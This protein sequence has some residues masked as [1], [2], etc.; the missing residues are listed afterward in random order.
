MRLTSNPKNE[1]W[2]VWSPDGTRIVFSSDRAGGYAL[3]QR[4]SSGTGTEEQL[5]AVEGSNLGAEHLSSDGRWL[6]F[7][8]F[9]PAKG[10]DIYLLPMEGT[11]QPVPYLKEAAGE[12]SPRFS[13]DGRWIAYTSNETG[14]AEVYVQPYPASGAKWTISTSGGSVPQWRADGKELFYQ[15]PDEAI[16]GVAMTL[17]AS[18]DAGPPKQLFRRH[19]QVQGGI[20]RNRWAVTADGQ[21]FLL[22]VALEEKVSAPFSLVLDWPQGMTPAR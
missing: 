15:G 14:R 18:L 17:G 22:N 4:S 2:P 9:E 13:P 5:Y 7:D 8:R 16:Y 6:L 20:S 10:G 12:R 19:L 1:I 3:I 11:H 21:R